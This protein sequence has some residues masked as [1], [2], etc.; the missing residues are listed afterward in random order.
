LHAGATA[1]FLLPLLEHLD[2]ERFE[3]HLLDLSGVR[4]DASE[5]LARSADRWHQA[6]QDG[7][8][9]LAE[10]IRD[11]DIDILMDLAG[12]NP[13]GR[14]LVLARKPAPVIV[15]WLDYFNTTGLSTVD[16]LIGDPISTPEGGPQRFTER[17][18]RL[19]PCRFC[20]SPPMNAPPVSDGRGASSGA[21]T[22]GSFNRLSKLTPAVIGVW[23]RVLGQIPR[24]RLLL[25][26]RSFADPRTRDRITAAFGAA[27]IEG[28]RLDLRA[29]STHAQM[30]A[31]YGDIDIALDPFPYN[32]GLTTCEAL[33]MGVPVLALR[34]DSMISRQ[35]ASLL[36]AAG[37]A[38]WIADDERDL[39]RRA[40]ALAHGPD[41][42][43]TL[44][45]E[46]R[47]RLRGSALMDA[48]GFA[49]KFSALLEGIAP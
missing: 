33:W 3:V 16:Y 48:A 17:V 12:H 6:E 30:L 28:P 43:V 44:R 22:F 26:N 19:D 5:R 21:I 34:G 35:S 11:L 32:G 14:P 27:G 7:D 10:R 31:E 15:T 42:L 38:D 40:V 18:L 9:A 4:D 23:A 13:G 47:N 8:D 45:R 37:L 20:Y 39:I 41:A 46:L 36:S 25:K 2:R 1:T 24:S 49:R 29:D